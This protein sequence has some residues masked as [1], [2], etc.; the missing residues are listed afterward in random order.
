MLQHP[1]CLLAAAY[2]IIHASMNPETTMQYSLS[3]LHLTDTSKAVVLI[4]VYLDGVD[5]VVDCQV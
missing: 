5:G 3:C 2:E 4:T 1:D